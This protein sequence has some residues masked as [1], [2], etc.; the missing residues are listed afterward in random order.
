MEW[1]REAIKLP[2]SANLEEVR[3]TLT[4]ITRWE[5]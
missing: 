2:A 5:N 3:I 1:L 4:L